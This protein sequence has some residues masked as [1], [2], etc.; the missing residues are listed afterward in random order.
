M[1]WTDGD[2]A[3][4]QA[5]QRGEA[6][7][8]AEPARQA[9]SARPASAQAVYALPY[10]PSVNRYWR[11]IGRGRVLISRDGREYREAVCARLVGAQAAVGR[12]AVTIQAT[13][14][15]RRARDLDNVLKATLDALTHGGAW[16][17]DSQIDDLRVVRVGVGKPGGLVVTVA[18]LD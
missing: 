1:R 10:P 14:P 11:S 3:A 7:A 15:D 2:L 13:M 18:G 8:A 5:R 4:L 17:D 6:H 16:M 9:A 12:L